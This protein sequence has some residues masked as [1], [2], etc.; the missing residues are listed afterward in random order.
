MNKI[1]P[2]SKYPGMWRVRYPDGS[3]SDMMSK[4]RACAAAKVERTYDQRTHGLACF[5]RGGG[6]YVDASYRATYRAWV[7]MMQRCYNPECKFYS[8]Y[9]GRGITVCPEWQTPAGFV[10]SMGRRPHPALSLDR[11]NNDGNYE[12]TNCR[13]ATKSE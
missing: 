7:N 6:D 11:F 2:D 4:P 12:P 9:G 13:W 8:Y 10:R 1:E 5:S 3:L